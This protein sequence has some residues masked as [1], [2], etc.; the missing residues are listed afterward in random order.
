MFKTID[1]KIINTVWYDIPIINLPSPCLNFKML[2]TEYVY[3]YL[4]SEPIWKI[5]K[6][7]NAKNCNKINNNLINLDLIP[8]TSL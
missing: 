5:S 3:I 7:I 1:I 6:F 2:I 8:Y 4:I